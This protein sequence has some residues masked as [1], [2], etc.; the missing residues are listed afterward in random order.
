MTEGVLLRQFI[1][2]PGHDKSQ[3][4]KY[5]VIIVDEAHERSTQMVVEFNCCLIL[6]KI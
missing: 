4:D 1:K 3:L 2:P 6:L 5:S